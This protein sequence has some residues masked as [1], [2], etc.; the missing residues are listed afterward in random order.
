LF[1]LLLFFKLKEELLVVGLLDAA[2]AEAAVFCATCWRVDICELGILKVGKGVLE[3]E[4]GN[5]E[6]VDEICC[7]SG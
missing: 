7:S 4:E 2:A 3:E 1:E 6:V 5:E